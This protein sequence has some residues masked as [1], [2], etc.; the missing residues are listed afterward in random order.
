MQG[1]M[2]RKMV[3]LRIGATIISFTGRRG[4]RGRGVLSQE[5]DAVWSTALLL[6]LLLMKL[7]RCGGGFVVSSVFG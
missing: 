2:M 4:R 5:T 6:L 3:L 1:L 7:Q